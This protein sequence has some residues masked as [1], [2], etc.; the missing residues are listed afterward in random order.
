MTG[1][2]LIV[3]TDLDGT[4][5]DHDDY[6]FEPARPSL[7]ELKRRQVPLLLCSSKTR[8]EME[9]LQRR[10]GIDDPFICE[11][12]AAICTP[13][14]GSTAVDAMA[15]PREDVLAVLRALR[16][17]H[18][19]RFTGFNDCDPAEIAAM[20][21][22]DEAAAALAAMREFSEP[23]RW[24][25]SEDA[26]QRFRDCLADSELVA[27]QGGRFLAVGGRSDKGAALNRLRQRYG[28]GTTLIAL[29]DSPND[30]PM[31]AVADIAVIIRSQRSASVTPVGPGR[32][33]RT[34]AAGPSGWQEAMASLL[35]E[36][37]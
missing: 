8:V 16:E 21:G 5:L 29:G 9:A 10:L 3:A 17:R 30:E 25:D 35:A 13:Q 11:N 37:Q 7:E 4:L 20:T 26:L 23:L 1:S 19:F 2:R 6:N 14:G 36:F 15:P 12:G 24:E 27:Q 33:L 32:I 18:G 28:S 34:R 22:L 31:L